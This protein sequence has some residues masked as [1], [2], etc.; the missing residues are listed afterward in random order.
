MTAL[1]PPPEA[2]GAAP[3]GLAE[4]PQS[5]PPDGPGFQGALEES[6]ARTALAEGHQGEE[7]DETSRADR[8]DEARGRDGS[9]S[10]SSEAATSVGPAR[11]TQSAQSTPGSP[12]QARESSA[13]TRSGNA[14]GHGKPH[15]SSET[16]GGTPGVGAVVAT[17]S[18]APL[19]SVPTAGDTAKSAPT[20]MGAINSAALSS[21]A[22]TPDSTEGRQLDATTSAGAD[23]GSQTASND[24]IPSSNVG[25]PGAAA[26]MADA[27]ASQ[28]TSAEVAPNTSPKQMQAPAGRLSP[29]PAATA[30]PS[31][32]DSKPATMPKTGA[33]A[34]ESSPASTATPSA[35]R[36][37][38][39]WLAGSEQG[40]TTPSGNLTTPRA[41]TPPTPGAP[42]QAAASE[43]ATAMP[44][45]SVSTTTTA[46]GH[47][48]AAQAAAESPQAP[49]GTPV[50]G[51]GTPAGSTAPAPSPSGQSAT[52]LP[53]NMQETIETIHATVALASR[54]GAAQAQISLEPAELGAVR[55][56]LAQT[57]EGLTARVSAETVAGA[58]A[59]AS[60]QSE[61]HNTLSSLGIS[62]LRLDIGAFAHQ[63]AQTGGQTP[64]QSQQARPQAAPGALTQDAEETSTTT[65]T[66]SLSSNSALIDVLA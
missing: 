40:T 23:T 13:P 49:A 19:A 8:R 52:Y 63:E 65:G 10:S 57:S 3:Q 50:S 1:A 30:P 47:L 12:A 29:P 11:P 4:M 7:Q 37:H 24:D 27:A 34:P 35:V 22:T 46:A 5:K 15:L 61:L 36:L 6:L 42:K 43:A 9:V 21:N 20:K 62:L 41:S 16:E 2:L 58:Q 56:H 38:L 17:T 66:I 28:S 18:T 51:V 44:T 25:A 53:N 32:S 39:P 54:Q 33:S 45:P 31:S 59:I 26:D 64:Q 48:T 55:I 60:G 14:H